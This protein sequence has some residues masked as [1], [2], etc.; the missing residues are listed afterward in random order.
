VVSLDILLI[1]NTFSGNKSPSAAF[2]STLFIYRPGVLA[3][4]AELDEKK[5]EL[6]S[7]KMTDV[8]NYGALNL[9][10]GLGYKLGLFEAMATFDTPQTCEDLARKAGVSK[11]YAYE[12]LGIM[13]TGGIV[14]LTITSHDQ[15]TYYLPPEHRAFLLRGSDLNLGV[16][17]QEIPMLTACAQKQVEKSFTTGHGVSSK[18]YP[19]FQSFMGEL[20]DAKHQQTLL[21]T[22][23]PSVDQGRLVTALERG[24]NV[25]DLG[26]GSGLAPLLMAK[27]FPNSFFMGIDISSQAIGLARKQAAKARLSNLDFQ[28]V[29][30]AKI[31]QENTFLERFDYITAFDAIHD[32]PHPDQAL[33]GVR[34]MLKPGG[35]FSMVD[36]AAQSG[37][38]GNLDHP[39]G[40]FL[41]A[42]S[43]MHC[44]P[45]GLNDQGQGLGMMW[46]RQKAEK[47]LQE[48]GFSE[49]QVLDIPFDPFNLH[50]QCRK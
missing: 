50:F 13:A 47:M 33:I 11:R 35:L 19:D 37:H 6:F 26:C 3:K 5:K 41:Y 7:Q 36:I 34:H 23:L 22:F 43:M 18:N 27:A 48:A 49:V 2:E 20:A 15:E 9:A 16:Y 25:C 44:L 46:G 1:K 4:M 21:Q 28:V 32:Q 8:L 38:Q 29:D 24:I 39:M 42:V 45:Q 10:M 17:T 31:K 40:P 30:A 14:E 12:W